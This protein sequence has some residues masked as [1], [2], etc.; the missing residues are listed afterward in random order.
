VG[1]PSIP[2]QARLPSRKM[3][4][5]LGL[6]RCA[7]AVRAGARGPT[8]TARATISMVDEKNVYVPKDAKGRTSKKQDPERALRRRYYADPGGSQERAIL[9]DKSKSRQIAK[10]EAAQDYLF[11]LGPAPKSAIQEDLRRHSSET[12]VLS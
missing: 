5:S 10:F 9:G 6:F 4:C 12:G 11:F 3:L 8:L 7:G 2:D 1:F